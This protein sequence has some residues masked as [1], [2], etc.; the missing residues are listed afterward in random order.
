MVNRKYTLL[1]V[2]IV[3]L[4][5]SP[6]LAQSKTRKL[7]TLIGTYTQ[8]MKFNGTILVSKGNDILLHKGYGYCDV[9]RNSGCDTN[10][11]FKIGDITQVF[12]SALVFKLDEE[13]KLSINDKVSK[14]LPDYPGG[15]KITLTDLLTHRSGIPDYI[16]DDEFIN[17]NMY[18]PTKPEKV[19]NSFKD[20]PLL[21][22]PGTEY[23]YSNSNYFLLGYIVDKATEEGYYKLMH[24]YVFE[25]LKMNSSGFDLPGLASW[26]KAQGYTILN[27]FR[28]LPSYPADS[29]VTSAAAGMFS[30]A[31]DLHKFT[32]AMLKGKLLSDSLWK[33][34]T[35]PYKKGNAYGWDIQKA[36]G[37]KALRHKGD[38]LGFVSSLMVLPE[39]SLSVIILCN[40]KE[41]HIDDVQNDVLAIVYDKPY[42]LPKL[43]THVTLP[44]AK[45]KEY[46]GR[47]E[48]DG[49]FDLN[50]Y[51]ENGILMCQVGTSDGVGL[52]AEK[53]DYFFLRIVDAQFHFTRGKDGKVDGVI[54]NEGGRIKKGRKW[55]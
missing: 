1:L 2:A 16:K 48:M 3:Q 51:I 7:D 31:A 36:Y 14:Y 18:N 8:Q 45:L 35:S 27:Q 5:T 29:S 38:E 15:D 49:G 19:I 52:F 43:K 24:K 46:T 54:L 21:F 47:Y 4:L 55:Q 50:L 53:P 9:S 34:V 32:N 10:S 13:G 28:V 44:Y 20:K 12:T 23:G 6:L 26:D 11:I 37:K 22:K 30:T 41:V 33:V 40:D 25:P 39:D 42:E 17:S